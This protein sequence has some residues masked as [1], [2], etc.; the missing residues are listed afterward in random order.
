MVFGP[1]R[2]LASFSRLDGA[3]DGPA[4]ATRRR[5]S[6]DDSDFSPPS[7]GEEEEEEEGG[8]EGD[9]VDDQVHELTQEVSASV[10]RWV[11]LG[12]LL[13]NGACTSRG[14]GVVA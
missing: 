10:E 7:H 12:P 1:C 4:A 11:C 6:Q 14:Q 3:A 13:W 5:A 2:A 9:P 8:G